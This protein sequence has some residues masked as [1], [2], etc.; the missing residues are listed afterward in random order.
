[1][2]TTYRDGVLEIVLPTE[3]D[4]ADGVRHIDIEQAA[5]RTAETVVRSAIRAGA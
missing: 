3:R 1:M 2:R 4:D 5:P